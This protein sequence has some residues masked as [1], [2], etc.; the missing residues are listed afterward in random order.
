MNT[1]SRLTCVSSLIVFFLF[2]ISAKAQNEDDIIRF[3]QAGQEDG[4]KLITA[5]ISPMIEGFSYALNGAWFHTAKPHKLGGFDINLAVTPVF[6]PKSK[7]FFDPEA[8]NMTTVVGY[9]NTTN[10]GGKAPTIIGP[11]DRTTYQVDFD[12][13]QQADASFA[14][15][16]GLG[17]R[18]TLKVAPVGLP[19]LQVGI[20]LVK[21]T[22]LMVRFIPKTNVG[23]TDL[24][25]IG[26]GVRH[27]VKQHIPGIKMLPFDLSVMAGYTSF[28]GVT[29]LAGLATEFPPATAGTTQES[30][31]KFN[32]FMA[33][34]LI[35]K[36]LA[37]VTFFGGV[38]FNGINTTADVKGSY[39]F[40]DGTPGEFALTNPYSAKFKSSSMRLDVGMRINLLAFYIY[41]NYSVQEFNA[42]T[43]GLGFTFR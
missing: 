12:G 39:T 22:D 17:V 9:A 16:Q 26:F 23:S 37:F 3:L 1:I 13:D 31:Y 15:P 30:I 32:A 38:G 40:F 24:N 34:A 28:K 25:L 36:K 35:S 43:T 21:G 7:D 14:G 4:G 29:N 8:L 27:D 33:E 41:G 2:S 19:M 10:P 6:I 42:F 18:K 5:Y 11:K 20:G